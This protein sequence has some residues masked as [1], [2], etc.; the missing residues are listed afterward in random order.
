MNVRTKNEG[1]GTWSQCFTEALWAVPR[2]PLLNV[3]TWDD[4]VEFCATGQ[5]K[6][7][8]IVDHCFP[9][10]PQASTFCMAIKQPGF[11]PVLKSPR[12][13]HMWPGCS[14]SSKLGVANGRELWWDVPDA[15]W[16]ERGPTQPNHMV[17]LYVFKLVQN[18]PKSQSFTRKVSGIFS[19]IQVSPPLQ[20][21]TCLKP[22]GN[23]NTN[24]FWLVGRV[25]CYLLLV[26]RPQLHFKK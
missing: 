18:H 21:I 24:R 20:R 15:P 8:L 5:L 2:I 13:P 6:R 9:M 26:D 23:P 7:I 4:S 25:W 17:S 19:R 22:S 16:V 10:F 12:S 14:S 3:W 1:T 11:L